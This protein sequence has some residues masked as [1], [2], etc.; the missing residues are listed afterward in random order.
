MHS[1]KHILILTPGFARDEADYLCIP[2]LQA[3]L[4]ALQAAEPGIRITVVAL[5]YPYQARE[6]TWKGISVHALGG[7]NVRTP[8]GKLNLW[9]KA[10]SR[11]KAIHKNH[12]VDVIHSLWMQECTWLG[13]GLARKYG[14]GQVATVQG[15]D[16]MPGNRYLSRIRSEG[17]DVVVLSER[18]GALLSEQWQ[19]KMTLN[20]WGLGETDLKTSPQKERDIDVLGVGSLVPVK[21]WSLFV[22]TIAQ[23]SQDNPDLQVKLLGEGP[24]RSKLEKQIAEK[25]LQKVIELKGEVPREEVL[26]WMRRSKVLLHTAHY[27]GQGYIFPEAFSQGMRIVSTPVGMAEAGPHWQLGTTASAL[28]DGLEAGLQAPLLHTSLPVRSIEETVAIYRRIY[29]G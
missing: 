22:D 28:A 7:N 27:E 24:E 12:P 13:Q 11:F 16:V 26:A 8:W 3:Y 4:P 19:G 21:N 18:A 17:L 23:L 9:R 15:Q 5:H 6:Y 10:R 1:N 29:A 20:P 14:L 2:P 25:G